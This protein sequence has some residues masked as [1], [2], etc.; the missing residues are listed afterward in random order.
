[1][2]E[3]NLAM[4]AKK[5][6]KKFKLRFDKTEKCGILNPTPQNTEERWASELKKILKKF[7][8]RFDKSSNCDILNLTP[9]NADKRP[10]GLK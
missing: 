2:R 10:A 6:W 4:A 9:Q 3:L 1:M 7:E 5:V 8:I